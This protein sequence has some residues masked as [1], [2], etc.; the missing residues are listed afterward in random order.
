MISKQKTRKA[1]IGGSFDPPGI[2]H[3]IVIAYYQIGAELLNLGLVDHLCFIP[4]GE[5][6]DKKL[7]N[8]PETRLEMLRLSVEEYFGSIKDHV[9]VATI[10]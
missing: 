8:R 4:C 3:L 5:R 9:S 2:H 7:T 6:T 1:I 10:Q